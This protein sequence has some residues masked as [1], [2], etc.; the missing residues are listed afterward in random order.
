MNVQAQVTKKKGLFNKMFGF[1]KTAAVNVVRA[2]T[3]M[4]PVTNNKLDVEV[5][6]LEENDAQNTAINLLIIERLAELGIDLDITN[7]DIYEKQTEILSAYRARK[8][9]EKELEKQ[10]RKLE[11]MA[12]FAEMKKQWDMND[13]KT[14]DLS[15]DKEFDL[16]MDEENYDI[17]EV[18]DGGRSGFDEPDEDESVQPTTSYV[19]QGIPVEED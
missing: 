2:V 6:K 12:K 1:D 17:H 10:A 9:D 4:L 13:V 14:P 5:A 16:V 19:F 11:R 18:K 15:K 8:E 7:Q 3:G